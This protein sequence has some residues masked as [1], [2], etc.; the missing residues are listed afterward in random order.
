MIFIMDPIGL[1]Q[2]KK[3]KKKK[4]IGY[5]K[6]RFKGQLNATTFSTTPLVFVEVGRYNILVFYLI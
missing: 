6:R 5:H 2:K 3:K 1:G 4:K